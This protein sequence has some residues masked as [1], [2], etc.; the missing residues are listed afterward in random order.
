MGRVLPLY[1]QIICDLITAIMNKWFEFKNDWL[2]IIRIKNN[3]MQFCLI[4]L[5]EIRNECAITVPPGV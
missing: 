3:Y 2:K 1:T 4:P 5:H